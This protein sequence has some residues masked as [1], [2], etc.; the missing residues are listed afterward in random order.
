MDIPDLGF[1]FVIDMTNK[2]SINSDG[3]FICTFKG[4]NSITHHF[5]E[6]INNIP[7]I[8]NIP[9]QDYSPYTQSFIMKFHIASNNNNIAL[10]GPIDWKKYSTIYIDNEE[11]CI[12]DDVYVKLIISI[13]II[14]Q[15]T[16]FLKPLNYITPHFDIYLNIVSLNGE[17]I[18][19]FDINKTIIVEESKI[20]FA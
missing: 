2:Q 17:N 19:N 16:T 3:S 6:Y 8:N 14:E 1:Q 11:Y 5:N 4:L 7:S 12:M 10:I 13:V 20:I 9:C 15:D 18:N